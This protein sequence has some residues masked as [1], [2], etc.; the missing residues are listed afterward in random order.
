MNG[1]FNVTAVAA[2]TIWFGVTTFISLFGAAAFLVLILG[3]A[4]RREL[5]RGSGVL[6]IHLLAVEFCMVSIH[7]PITNTVTFI[8]RYYGDP[9]LLRS[10]DCALIQFFMTTFQH[11]GNWASFFLAINRFFAILVPHRYRAIS[12]SSAI[13]GMILSSW[14]I[15]LCCNLPLYFGVGGVIGNT[16]SG[17]CGLLKT[18]KIDYPFRAA[19]AYYIPLISL[20]IIYFTLFMRTNYIRRYRVAVQIPTMSQLER[21][22]RRLSVTKM[23]FVSSVFYCLCYFPAPVIVT[24]FPSYSFNNRDAFLY[25]RMLVVCG[26]ASNPVGLNL[27][28]RKGTM[29]GSTQSRDGQG[30]PVIS[31]K[32]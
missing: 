21:A 31:Q 18:S 14:A 13:L 15:S 28:D 23:L 6:I 3:I 12:S 17:D 4:S 30:F 5:H 11:A 27:G 8:A 25:I 22:R 16:I 10:L 1:T 7:Y 24:F 2:V 29:D 19:F 32:S 26:Y 9:N 20:I